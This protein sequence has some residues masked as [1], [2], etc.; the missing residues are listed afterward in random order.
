MGLRRILHDTHLPWPV[1]WEPVRIISKSHNFLFGTTTIQSFTFSN[2][3]FFLGQSRHLSS[4]SIMLYLWLGAKRPTAVHG[5]V[6]NS[7]WIDE[8][9]QN[10]K[11]LKD[12][13]KTLTN[14]SN[15][16]RIIYC[17][18][19]NSRKRNKIF[20]MI[21]CIEVGDCNTFAG[22]WDVFHSISNSIARM[23]DPIVFL[24]SNSFWKRFA[25]RY[26]HFIIRIFGLKEIVGS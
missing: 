9:K 17:N 19:W 11:T 20:A 14:S 18:K 8:T 2:S 21:I 22:R 12:K 5:K 3:H 15:L 25:V 24:N 10:N 26:I 7:E 4:P 13:M 23:R 6:I 1:G 16:R